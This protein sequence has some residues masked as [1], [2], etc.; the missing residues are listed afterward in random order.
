MTLTLF[1]IPVAVYYSYIQWTHAGPTRRVLY[2]FIFFLLLYGS[3]P[4]SGRCALVVV[5]VGPPFVIVFLYNRTPETDEMTVSGMPNNRIVFYRGSQFVI[6]TD[7]RPF[8]LSAR[9]RAREYRREKCA[10]R[11][12]GVY[13]TNSRGKII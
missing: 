13:Y 9:A 3:R 5:V 8:R 12:G 10:H 2:L 4:G 1:S 6:P 11:H 7:G